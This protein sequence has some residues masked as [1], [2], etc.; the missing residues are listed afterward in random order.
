MEASLGSQSSASDTPR[1]AVHSLTQAYERLVELS[2]KQV[3]GRD[4]MGYTELLVLFR[5]HDLGSRVVRTPGEPPIPLYEIP[6]SRQLLYAMLDLDYYLFLTR[7]FTED[8]RGKELLFDLSPEIGDRM[9]EEEI[10]GT[11]GDR[12]ELFVRLDRVL[13]ALEDDPDEARRQNI[14]SAHATS[15]AQSA[16]SKLP[17]D[18]YVLSDRHGQFF[19]VRGGIRR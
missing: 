17:R 6:S 3:S 9:S 14:E 13:T 19:R 2:P 5:D 10:A 15:T 8:G 11:H 18:L 4:S 12:N 1:A 16:P 7:G